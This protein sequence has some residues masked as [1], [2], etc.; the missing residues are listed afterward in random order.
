MPGTAIP[1]DF[2]PLLD[3][4]FVC[5]EKITFAN[6]VT[7]NN[8]DFIAG[9]IYVSANAQIN[10]TL[11]SYGNVFVGSNAY[12]H[13]FV[14]GGNKQ[15]QQ[16]AIIVNYREESIA[17]PQVPTMSFSYGVDDVNVM[18]DNPVVL[19]PGSYRNINVFTNAS[20]VF[21]PGVYYIK[22][23]YVAPD[24]SID[25]QTTHERVQLWIQDDVSIGDRSTFYCRGG[26]SKCFIYGNNTGYMYL[27][28]NVNV[29]AYVAYPYGYVELA[30]NA[31]LSGAIWA[32][33]VTAGANAIIK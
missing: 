16:G 32:K 22:S 28:V 10:G 19:H 4:K 26:A 11:M 8:G 3:Y 27:G 1:Q 13:T 15:I 2:G 18:S 9:L 24:A 30:P 20:V 6:F 33:S 23:L 14:V 5:G 25:L 12:I 31:T 21:E 7:V 17:V 29:D